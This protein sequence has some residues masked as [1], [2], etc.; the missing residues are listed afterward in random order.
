[1]VF[2]FFVSSRLFHVRACRICAYVFFIDDVM[3]KKNV[4]I[5]SKSK[6]GGL[7]SS[8]KEAFVNFVGFFRNP[9]TQ[10]VIGMLFA[11]FAKPPVSTEMT[12]VTST[13]FQ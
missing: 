9:N 2:N 13:A 3:A 7:F 8:L 12:R 11:A 5:N 1:M 4:K 10:F 6:K